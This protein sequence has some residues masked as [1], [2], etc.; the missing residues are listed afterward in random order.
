M[1]LSLKQK[2]FAK[3]KTPLVVER[4]GYRLNIVEVKNDAKGIAVFAQAWK[5]GKQ[6][7]FGLDGSVDVERFRLIDPAVCVAD[8]NGDIESD[9]VDSETGERKV[10]RLREDPQE[11]MVRVLLRTVKVVGIADAEIQSGKI[12]NTTTVVRSH[13]T[14]GGFD[15]RAITENQVTWNDAVTETTA[16]A[17]NNT[18]NEHSMIIAFF[19]LTGSSL[20]RYTIRRSWFAFDTSSIPDT[21]TIS[22]ATFTIYG[23]G[24]ASEDDSGTTVD[25][26]SATTTSGTEIAVGDFGNTGSTVFADKAI[27]AWDTTDGNPNDFTLNASGIANISKTGLSKFAIKAGIDT[28]NNFPHSGYESNSVGGYFGDQTGVDTDPTLTV[29]HSGGAATAPDAF[30]TGEWSVADLGTKGD[31]RITISTLPDN[32]GSAITDLEY[33]LDGGSWVSLSATTTGTYDIAGLTDGTEYSVKVRAVNAEG[34]GADSD[35][36][37]VTPTGVPEAFTSGL[38]SVNDLGTGGDIRITISTLPAANGTAITDLEYKI[39]A[40]SWTSLSGTTTGNYDISGL[41]DDVEVDV[42]IRAVNATGNGADSDTKAV[43]PTTASG[44]PT[45]TTQ[46]VSDITQTTATGNGNVTA[47]G[48]DTVTERGVCW[49]TSENPTTASDKATAAGT[50]GAYTADITGLDPNTTYY[51]RAYAINT[52]GTSYGSQV[53]FTTLR[54]PYFAIKRLNAATGVWEFLG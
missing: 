32:G 16:D 18:D 14:E 49:S 1:K 36:K 22:S 54:V 34:N 31:I 26:V 19:G 52:N 39:D 33:Q 24:R 4:E 44:T 2:K 51:V 8:P 10:R 12:G 47:D 30:V 20:E 21:D 43:T 37:T 40:G 53:S 29:V 11:A 5:D 50:T 35:A 7:G 48:G 28:D 41:T 6:L 46:A 15:A 25:V 9:W 27:S 3:I 38:W 17:V 42:L 23:S 45:V 13:S